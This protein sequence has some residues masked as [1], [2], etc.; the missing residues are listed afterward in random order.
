MTNHLSKKLDKT[1]AKIQNLRG[2]YKK[3]KEFL[4]DYLSEKR[5]K[6]KES[7]EKTKKKF[8]VYPILIGLW[9]VASCYLAFYVTNFTLYEFSH[10]VITITNEDAIS[11]IF[12]IWFTLL[13]SA[14]SILIS[15]FLHLENKKDKEK[16]LDVHD[17][18]LLEPESIQ[19][20]I[21]KDSNIILDA[22][23][24]HKEFWL[25]KGAVKYKFLAISPRCDLI[26]LIYNSLSGKKGQRI[27]CLVNNGKAHALGKNM[28]ILFRKKKI[29]TEEKKNGKKIKPVKQYV[30]EHGYF[31]KEELDVYSY[32]FPQ[33]DHGKRIFIHVDKTKGHQDF[34]RYYKN[35]EFIVV[36][37]YES[38]PSKKLIKQAYRAV[39]I[40]YNKIDGQERLFLNNFMK[41]TKKQVEKMI[42]KD[43]A[44][45]IIK[46][47]VF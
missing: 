42:E 41:L 38:I 18:A 6:R 28:Y 7:F 21:L 3:T 27:F 35:K 12:I 20:A 15:L 1:K 16:D 13:A 43:L 30:K 39:V 34:T 33:N 4:K 26:K 25:G 37:E 46:H 11:N 40:S 44:K 17:F 31:V 32:I 9:I 2:W 45:D 22:S 47:S 19:N 36:V 8:W 24:L 29:K 23:S 10:L 5:D 14:G